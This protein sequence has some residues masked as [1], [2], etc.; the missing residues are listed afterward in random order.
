LIY[1]FLYQL[2]ASNETTRGKLALRKSRQ[3]KNSLK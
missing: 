1:E 3:F 2:Q